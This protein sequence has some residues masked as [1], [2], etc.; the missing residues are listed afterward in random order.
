MRTEHAAKLVGPTISRY[1]TS[2]GLFWLIAW[3]KGDLAFAFYVLLDDPE[4]RDYFA[5][6]RPSYWTSN[7]E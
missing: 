4:V 5:A 3:M 1:S 2:R 7:L 6:F